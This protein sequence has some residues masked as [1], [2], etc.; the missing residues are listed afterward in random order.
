MLKPRPG[1][2]SQRHMGGKN[3]LGARSGFQT[4]FPRGEPEWRLAV[5]GWGPLW[6]LSISVVF[7]IIADS[8]GGAPRVGQG[9]CDP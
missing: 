1:V 2:S 4:A 9:G 3:R 7:C 6:T 5:S 8:G